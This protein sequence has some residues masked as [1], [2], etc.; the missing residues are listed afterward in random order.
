MKSDTTSKNLEAIQRFEQ[1]GFEFLPTSIPEECINDIRAEILEIAMLLGA[2]P[3]CASVDAA[4]NFFKAHD[5]PNGGLLY[6]ALKRL[7][8]VHRLCS[9]NALLEKIKHATGFKLPAIIDVNCRIDSNGEDKYL[10]DW[11]Q[12]YWFSVS[13][14]NALVVWIPIE[15]IDSGTGGIEL[16]GNDVTHGR[17]FRTS[18]GTEYNSYADAFRLSE[19]VPDGATVSTQMEP[20]DALLFKFSV[21]H[22]SKPVLAADRS[23]FTM[24]FRYVDLADPYFLANEYKPG[25]VTKNNTDYLKQGT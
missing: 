12:D 13:S 9:G 8:S 11:H 2:P 21:L 25:S 14:P 6:N 1:L 4:W 16:F 10:F 23:R 18:G 19:V 22:R 20:G 3:S 7:P 17:I 24:Q 5:R 15:K